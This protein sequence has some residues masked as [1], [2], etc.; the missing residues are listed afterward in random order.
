MKIKPYNMKFLNRVRELYREFIYNFSEKDEELE[1]YSTLEQSK[2]IANKV[3][4]IITSTT[5]ISILFLVFAKTDQ[6]IIAQGDLQPTDRVREIKIPISGVVEKITIEEGDYVKENHELFIL[7]DYLAKETYQNLNKKI[8]LKAN[9]LFLKEEELGELIK[10]M[11]SEIINLKEI[12]KIENRHL[13]KFETLFT[14]GAISKYDYENQKIKLIKYK[15][16]LNNKQ[17]LLNEKE[18]QIKQQIKLIENNI[19][20]FKNQLE[21][22]K[23]KLKYSIIYS[24]ISGY[25]FELK[26]KDSGYVINPNIEL[27][28]IVPENNLEA[29]IYIESGD[30]GF[31]DLGRKVEL[32]I[33]SYP[34]SDF[35]ILNGS[36]SFV[37]PSS[38]KINSNNDGL[39]FR[40]KVQLENQNL[41]SASGQKLNLKPGMSLRA[42]IK[43]RKLSYL[44]L[45]FS[46]FTDKAKSIKQI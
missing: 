13:N 30:I 8:K 31:V 19:L 1:A 32:N 7:D 9:E 24:P 44:Q 38:S 15:S 27:M 37:S 12:I 39:F 2:L 16:E 4:W 34:S 29:V 42:N 6:I 40:A 17:S 3:I 41:I 43:L 46:L 20:D 36:I 45:I 28:K 26:A 14:A 22:V 25:V 23:E 18:F 21:I 10:N 5:G 35:G 11:K 33:D